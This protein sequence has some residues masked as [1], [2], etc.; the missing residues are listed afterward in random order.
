MFFDMYPMCCGDLNLQ[1]PEGLILQ[2]VFSSVSVIQKKIFLVQISCQISK[3]YI[4]Y[5]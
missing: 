4:L 2:K 1:L 5:F 3:H